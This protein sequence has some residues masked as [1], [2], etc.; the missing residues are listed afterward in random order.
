MKTWTAT[1]LAS[2][3][4]AAV[5]HV[6][7]DPDACTRW[8][9]VPFDVEDDTRRLAKGSRARVTGRLAGQRVGFDV[10]VRQADEHGLALSADGPVAFD[11]DYRLAPTHAGSEVRASVSLRP[12]RGLVGRLLAEATGALLSAGALDHALARLAHEAATA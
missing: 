6:L 8:S 3:N 7:T 9:P 5:L 1:A 2:A 12:R 4:P 10:E 11:V